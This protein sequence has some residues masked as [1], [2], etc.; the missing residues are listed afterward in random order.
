[1]RLKGASLPYFL[2][3]LTGFGRR[4]LVFMPRTPSIMLAMGSLGGT[5][6]YLHTRKIAWLQGANFASQVE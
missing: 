5:G 4:S 3:S 1:M 6:P 2:R